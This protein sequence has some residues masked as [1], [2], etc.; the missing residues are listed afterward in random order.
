MSIVSKGIAFTDIVD[1]SRKPRYPVR[2][3]VAEEVDPV[4]TQPD[5]TVHFNLSKT[6]A[7]PFIPQE[8]KS[9]AP[10]VVPLLSEQWGYSTL[11]PFVETPHAVKKL[12]FKPE[13]PTSFNVYDDREEIVAGPEPV[14]Q[15]NLGVRPGERAIRFVNITEP[16]GT[17]Y[18]L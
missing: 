10:G 17:L 13:V 15:R 2:R 14:Y 8:A 1:K 16:A 9:F 11:Y 3:V 7:K 5:Q 12:G 18:R 4:F 6:I